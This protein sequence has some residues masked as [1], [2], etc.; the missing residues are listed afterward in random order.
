MLVGSI[1]FGNSADRFGRK[2]VMITS[3][4]FVLGCMLGVS[5]STSVEMYMLFRTST[6]IFLSGSNV[7]SFV[8][9]MEILPQKWIGIFGVI[10]QGICTI[11]Y[12]V[13]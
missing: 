2:P 12:M 1:V 4:V 11:G 13:L 10:Y 3:F 6:A 9:A 8:Y 5:L 7:G